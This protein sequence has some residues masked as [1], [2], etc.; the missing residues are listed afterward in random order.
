[1]GL[2]ALVAEPQKMN[3][4]CGFPKKLLYFYYQSKARYKQY[5][6]FP[7]VNRYIGMFFQKYTKTECSLL[8]VL[9]SG[10]INFRE[11]TLLLAR[12]SIDGLVMH[13]NSAAVAT[14]KEER[15]K[16]IFYLYMF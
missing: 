11:G 2:K 8:I 16:N 10:P 6:V 3:F 9:Y 1:M 5:D 7:L 12:N 4:F 14:L 15:K 13:F